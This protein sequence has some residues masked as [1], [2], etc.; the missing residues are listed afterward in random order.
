MENAVVK[1]VK[2]DIDEEV[3]TDVDIDIVEM[4]MDTGLE[5]YEYEYPPPPP[6]AISPPP[7]SSA[8]HQLELEAECDAN[9]GRCGGEDRAPDKKALSVAEQIVMRWTEKVMVEMGGLQQQQQQQQQEQPGEQ[10]VVVMDYPAPVSWQ[11]LHR[12]NQNQNRNI[13]PVHIL[14]HPPHARFPPFPHPQ[15]PH[16]HL[17]PQ[18]HSL[19][20][21]I[22]FFSPSAHPQTSASASIPTWAQ[23]PPQPVSAL[24]RLLP[25]LPAQQ[26]ERVMG[27]GGVSHPLALLSAPPQHCQDGGNEW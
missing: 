25:A 1:V 9:Y 14:T 10:K 20:P 3:G 22:P 7:A 17:L 8:T 23:A 13:T 12:Q 21:L 2:I 24:G 16:L 18:Q 6:T 27:F 19:P 4:D 26:Q 11:N 15:H 5:M